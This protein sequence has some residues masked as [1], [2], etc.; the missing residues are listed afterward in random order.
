MVVCSIPGRPCKQFFNPGL[1]KI[2]KALLV[3]VIVIC[4]DHKPIWRDFYKGVGQASTS[5][6]SILHKIIIIIVELAIYTVALTSKKPYYNTLDTRIGEE[7]L[8]K[9]MHVIARL[10]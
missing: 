3:S 5:P 4:S 7:Q 6:E 9:Q 8:R 2:N 10:P 1:Q